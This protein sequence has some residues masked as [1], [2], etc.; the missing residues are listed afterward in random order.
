M[1]PTVPDVLTELTGHIWTQNDRDDDDDNVDDDDQGE[2]EFGNISGAGEGST[3]W[4]DQHEQ[5]AG[6]SQCALLPH[7][8]IMMMLL[9]GVQ[10]MAQMDQNCPTDTLNGPQW[11]IW[12][13]W[14]E[15]LKIAES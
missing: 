11:S 5:S 15:L 4:R 1:V 10:K 13:K 3:I 6:V 7:T 12:S 8:D 9:Q 14:P 2:Q